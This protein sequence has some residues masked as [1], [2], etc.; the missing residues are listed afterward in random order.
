MK[1]GRV[2]ASMSKGY[3]TQ[4]YTSRCREAMHFDKS[5]G[6]YGGGSQC[7]GYMASVGVRRAMLM[8]GRMGGWGGGN[9]I[10]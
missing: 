9:A 5:R 1:G 2:S 6:V 4:A 10:G 7:G 3:V 8:G